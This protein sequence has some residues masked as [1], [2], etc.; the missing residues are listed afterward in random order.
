MIGRGKAPGKDVGSTIHPRMRVVI[1]LLIFAAIGLIMKRFGFNRPALFLGFVLGYLFEKYFFI[2]LAMSGPLFFMRP[3]SLGLIFFII[4]IF[5]LT[6]MRIWF[7]RWYGR[8]G[9]KA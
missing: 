2:A 7:Q 8:W 9:K 1:V 3:V 4:I 6:P 5:A